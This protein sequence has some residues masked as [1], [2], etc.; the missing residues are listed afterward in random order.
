MISTTMMAQA[1]PL[2]LESEDSLEPIQILPEENLESAGIVSSPNVIR[3]KRHGFGGF[4]RGF[5]G[6]GGYGRGYGGFGGYGG[7]GGFGGYGSPYG[8]GG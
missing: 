4:G 3:E 1:D 6:F 7:Y 8:Y 5:G 2:P